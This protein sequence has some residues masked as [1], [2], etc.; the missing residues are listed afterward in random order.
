MTYTKED[1]EAMASV[2]HDQ[3]MQWAKSLLESESLSLDRMHR[4]EKLMVPYDQLSEEMKDHDRQ[5][6]KAALE[7]YLSLRPVYTQEGDIEAMAEGI[8]QARLR[9]RFK[10]EETGRTMIPI[11][12]EQECAIF[13]AKAALD[14]SP[15]HAQLERVKAEN[16]GLMQIIESQKQTH[17][18]LIKRCRDLQAENERLLQVPV[19]AVHN[20]STIFGDRNVVLVLGKKSAE[21]VAAMANPYS[22]YPC[23]VIETTAT[24]CGYHDGWVTDC[25]PLNHADAG[26]GEGV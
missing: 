13:D 21:A 25:L 4:W 7:A 10:C 12:P 20:A 24:Q 1:I 3:W 22:K 14:A 2:E 9:E 8:V 15:V 6:A 5:W 19:Y 18:A 16:D 26:E 11:L 17:D 23:T